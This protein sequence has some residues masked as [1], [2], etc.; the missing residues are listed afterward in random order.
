VLCPKAHGP[1]STARR[2]LHV[3]TTQ[4]SGKRFV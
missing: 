2:L 1:P 4:H 3:A